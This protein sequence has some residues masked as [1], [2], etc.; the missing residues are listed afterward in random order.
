M[1]NETLA[2][3]NRRLDELT[4]SYSAKSPL[5]QDLQQTV[6]HLQQTLKNL[7]ELT[8]TISSRPSTLIFSDPKKPD[9]IPEP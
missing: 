6:I 1:A 9:P 4:A 2:L 8:V 7:D 5:Y 3:L